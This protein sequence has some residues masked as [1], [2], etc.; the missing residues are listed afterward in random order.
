NEHDGSLLCS[1]GAPFACGGSGMDAHQPPASG[2][3]VTSRACLTP[4]DAASLPFANPRI[5]A[6]SEQ[7]GDR[8]DV[9]REGSGPA[10]LTKGPEVTVS[11][12]YPEKAIFLRS[13]EKRL[14]RLYASHW[15]ESCSLTA[16]GSATWDTSSGAQSAPGGHWLLLVD[17]ANPSRFPTGTR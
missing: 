11:V 12:R 15:K 5:T 10:A 2:A 4:A 9:C 13:L 8:G 1:P 7:T 14:R 17:E 6:R 16:Q 3:P